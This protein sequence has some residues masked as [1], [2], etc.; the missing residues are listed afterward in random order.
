M[1][2]SVAAVSSAASL[3][4]ENCKPDATQEKSVAAGAVK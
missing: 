4:K 1:E 2:E 3:D